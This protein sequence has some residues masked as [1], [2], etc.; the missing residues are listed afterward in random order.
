MS[1]LVSM[2]L[3]TTSLPVDQQFAA[4]AAT[5][6]F[7]DVSQPRPA[8]GFVADAIGWKYGDLVISQQSLGLARFVRTARRIKA[9]GVDHYVLIVLL[10]GYWHGRVGQNTVEC[11]AGEACLFDL[12]RPVDAQADATT[13]ALLIP[14]ASIDRA[15]E[16]FDM[17]GLVHRGVGARLLIDHLRSVVGLLPSTDEAE[18]PLLAAATLGVLSTALNLQRLALPAPALPATPAQLNRVKRY[19]ARNLAQKLTA[20]TICDALAMSRSSLY[21]A[22]EPLGGVAAYVQQR[23]LLRVHELLS[24]PAESASITTLAQTHGFASASQ[25]SRAF[26]RAFGYSAADLR[27]RRVATPIAPSPAE[28][29][30][31][32]DLFTR[33]TRTL[34]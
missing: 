29:A 3:D 34:D 22:M 13:I 5:Q 8:A 12:G 1:L 19:I 9:D 2:R 27:A 25:F 32:A 23:R 18:A 26:R 24:L 16:P 33:W 10:E 7:Y 20:D 17:H 28:E 6:M 31:G 30:S 11:R 4:W 15:V 14:R 21:R